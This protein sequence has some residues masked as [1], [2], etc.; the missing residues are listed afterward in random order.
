MSSDQLELSVY[1]IVCLYLLGMLLAQTTLCDFVLNVFVRMLMPCYQSVVHHRVRSEKGRQLVARV[2]FALVGR[3]K[4][5]TRNV[6]TTR[7]V[8]HNYSIT[9][10]DRASSL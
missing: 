6:K 8:R 7:L 4:F 2:C 3:E 10:T 9:N 5:H 1:E